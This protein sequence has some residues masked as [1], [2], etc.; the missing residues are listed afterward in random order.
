[1]SAYDYIPNPADL[2]FEAAVDELR[3]RFPY[4]LLLPHWLPFVDRAH[5]DKLDAGLRAAGLDV[6]PF[7]GRAPE[8]EDYETKADYAGRYPTYH[9]GNQRE[10][11]F[12]HFVAMSLLNLGGD[13]VFIDVAA[14]SSPLPE[15]T[16][17]VYGCTS[18]GQDIM[19]PEGVQGQY[20]GGD[21][22]AM[23][24]PDGFATA[25]TLACSLEHFEG[26]GDTRLFRELGRVLRPGGRVVSVPLYLHLFAAAM[27]DPRYALNSDG[28]SFDPD[29]V[30]FCSDG[31]GNRHGRFYSPTTL[32]RRIL[33]PNQ[34]LFDFEILRIS[35]E[36]CLGHSDPSIYARFV[37]QAT[38]R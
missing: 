38:R 26:D 35:D 4:H 15:I 16:S 3:Q 8:L 13:D 22:C 33:E 2:T 18:Y 5:T 36:L 12:E 1:M 19:Y 17:R 30:V 9:D 23:P 7:E 25:A 31:W 21:A 24:V 27:T 28:L 6:K 11:R 10:K 34:D 37:L 14:C 32:K 29:T 20:I